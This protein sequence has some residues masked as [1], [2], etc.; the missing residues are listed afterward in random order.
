MADP[1]PTGQPAPI[2]PKTNAQQ[3]R[4]TIYTAIATVGTFL[5]ALSA[6][7]VAYAPQIGAAFPKY[8]DLIGKAAV[9][10]GFLALTHQRASSVGSETPVN[11]SSGTGQ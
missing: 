6:A 9:L 10:C 3:L 4:S 2:I 1:I 5:V 11:L 7:F 8:A